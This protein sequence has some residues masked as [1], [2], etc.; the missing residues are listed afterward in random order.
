[1]SEPKLFG[2][3]GYPV[4]HSY[5][6]AMHNA[7]LR[8]LKIKAAYRLF[9]KKPFE[10]KGFL[11][12][13]RKRNIRGLNVT[14]PYK[15]SVLQYL[16]RTSAAVK[17]IGACNTIIV[18]KDGA[19]KGFNTDYLGFAK[20]LSLL[21]VRPRKA[22]V[23]GAG[24]AAKAVCFALAKKN[25]EE[26]CLYDIDKFKSFDLARRF[27]E[28]FP[29]CRFL[30]AGSMEDLRLKHKDLL[31]NASPVGM[32]GNDRSPAEPSQLHPD[33][34]VYDLIYNPAMTRLLFLAKRQG[35]RFA[36]G[37]GMLLY[38]GAVSFRHFTKRNAP[39]KV[40]HRALMEALKND[41]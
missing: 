21:K 38:Q 28:I 17:A 39:V 11:L 40:M 12:S 30:V 27:N 18:E 33:I 31:V 15:E 36:N 19:L 6:P 16:D 35:C 8:A 26:V 34:F 4:K 22:A 3:L 9:A 2:L 5:S 7:A 14:I 20:D 24:G 13:L 29:S 1:M 37:L 10:V 32:H 41:R 23:I 25:A